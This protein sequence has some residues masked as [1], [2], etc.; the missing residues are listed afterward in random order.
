MWKKTSKFQMSWLWK[1]SLR[2]LQGL[3]VL[4]S[5]LP[6]WWGMVLR[7]GHSPGENLRGQATDTNNGRAVLRTESR[8]ILFGSSWLNEIQLVH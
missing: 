2:T 3:V 6:S 1:N 4:G 5:V 8:W 7:A